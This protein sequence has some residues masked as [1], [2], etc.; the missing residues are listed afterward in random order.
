MPL[1]ISFQNKTDVEWRFPFQ[2]GTKDD[3][4]LSDMLFCYGNDGRVLPLTAKVSGPMEIRV[5]I[6]KTF[7][8]PV[9]APAGT[10][11]ARAVFLNRAFQV[12]RNKEDFDLD[13]FVMGWHWSEHWQHPSVRQQIESKK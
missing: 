5:P 10:V 12:P 6:H 4:D 13:R 8:L 9:D 2:K 7:V 11:V 3:L 1:E